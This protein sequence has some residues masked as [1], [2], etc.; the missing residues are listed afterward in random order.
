LFSRPE[1]ATNI[2]VS[3]DPKRATNLTP[4]QKIIPCINRPIL[5]FQL[6]LVLF[7]A[8]LFAVNAERSVSLLGFTNTLWKYNDN[9]IE[10]GSNWRM[11]GFDDS[12]WLAG[13]ALLGVESTPGFYPFPFL[14]PLVL[15]P[16]NNVT[17]NFYFRTHFSI[18]A[19][20]LITGTRLM[21]TNYVDDGCVIYINGIEAGRLRVPTNQNAATYAS[22]SVLTNGDLLEG[23][24]EAIELTSTLLQAG[25]NVV[26]VEVHQGSANSSDV[27][28]A[29]NLTALIPTLGD[30]VSQPQSQQIESLHPF[31][32]CVEV[33]GGPVTYQW[34]TN[35]G[36]GTFAN[37]PGAVS[38]CYKTTS[39]QPVTNEYRVVCSTPSQSVTSAVAVVQV[40]PDKGLGPRV[41]SATVIEEPEAN[42]TNLIE[43]VFDESM[44]ISTVHAPITR[45]VLTN[46]TYRVTLLPSNIAI[47]ISNAILRPGRCVNLVREKAPFPV[48]FLTRRLTCHE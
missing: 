22:A 21:A 16:T 31:S 7:F 13:N 15:G 10:L 6:L 19:S 47:G 8:S 44:I 28:W 29:M 14:T 9:G 37:V 48:R 33:M 26:A 45:A 42:R 30:I 35:N 27:A 12:S 34:H 32:L 17:T 11:P 1:S 24:P 38:A 3:F 39:S 41:L 23:T 40:I 18:D 4:I 36:S 20:D 5:R 43:V 46:G 25:D 2:S